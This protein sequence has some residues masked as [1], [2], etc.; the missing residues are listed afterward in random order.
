MKWT[1]GA[2][3][4]HLWLQ[5]V[6]L[7]D[8]ELHRTYCDLKNAVRQLSYAAVALLK[9]LRITLLSGYLVKFKDRGRD[10]RLGAIAACARLYHYILIV[11]PHRRG[12]VRNHRS[13]CG[14]TQSR[15]TPCLTTLPCLPA[16]PCSAVR[17]R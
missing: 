16:A 14:L 5:F 4:S 10:A 17:R 12:A 7:V 15:D 3:V 9:T 2:D 1:N 8:S 13:G 11:P 6:S